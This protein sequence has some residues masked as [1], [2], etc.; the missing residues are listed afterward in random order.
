MQAIEA[1][2]QGYVSIM[3]EIG[4][5]NEKVVDQT[6]PV[7]IGQLGGGLSKREA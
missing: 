4:R 5:F 2:S 6:F 1:H 7:L 3:S